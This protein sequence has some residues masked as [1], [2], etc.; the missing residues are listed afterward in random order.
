MLYF[1]VFLANV[2]GLTYATIRT[3]LAGLRFYFLS[4]GLKDPTNSHGR[5]LPLI[6]M[7]LRGIKRCNPKKLN[8]RKPLSIAKLKMVVEAFS[9]LDIPVFEGL[10]AR[11][12]CL[13]AF[14]GFLRVNAYVSTIRRKDIHF[15]KLDSGEV[16]AR[17][18]LK[19]QKMRSS[20]RLGSIYTL[21][22]RIYAK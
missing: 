22:A 2:L 12:A 21:M 16:Y 15:G 14:W 7:L 11:T 20:T 18:Y 13:L 17:V 5:R 10:R 3:Y 19:R 1:I 4:H 9:N 6:N 8:R